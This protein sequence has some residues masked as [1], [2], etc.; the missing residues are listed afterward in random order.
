MKLL[1]SAHRLLRNRLIER[2]TTIPDFGSPNTLSSDDIYEYGLGSSSTL[3]TQSS[4]L[5]TV[6][7]K[8]ERNKMG[9]KIGKLFRSTRTRSSRS[10]KLSDLSVADE[11]EF[12]VSIA[13]SEGLDHDSF[14][15]GSP[16]RVAPKKKHGFIP[17][18]ILRKSADQAPQDNGFGGRMLTEIPSTAALFEN[19]GWFLSNLDHLCGNIERSLLKSFSKK[20][21][22]WALQP[23][24]DNKNRALVES[25]TDLRNGLRALNEKE[26]SAN[27]SDRHWSPVL[28]PM[29]SAELLLSIVPEESYILPSA[30]FPLLLT[31]DSCPR[32]GSNSTGLELN[33]ERMVHRTQVKVVSVRGADMNETKSAYIVN[34]AVGGTIKETG[35]R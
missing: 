23:W 14:E 18:S 22:E 10:K 1:T 3:Q 32:K 33:D 27:E 15:R 31:F 35:R 29:N 25:T 34:V 7:R 28:N 20:I 16:D 21:T 13:H 26:A 6:P 9:K 2:D 11:S 4:Q 30:H 19:M 24:N 8:S 17:T 5:S 12:S